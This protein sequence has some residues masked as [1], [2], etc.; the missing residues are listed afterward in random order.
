MKKSFEK[1]MRQPL[2]IIIVYFLVMIIAMLLGM[3]IFALIGSAIYDLSFSRLLNLVSTTPDIL[4]TLP[5]VEQDAY[6]FMNAYLNF[7][8]YVLIAL[9]FIIFGSFY[10]T[11]DFKKI[12]QNKKVFLVSL[13]LG[14]VVVGLLFGNS[15]LANYLVS[16]VDT[17][18]SSSVNQNLLVNM[19]LNGQ[20]PIV[21][22][23]V[24]IFAPIVEEMVFRK[25]IFNL[26][27]NIHPALRIILA[28]MIF[29]IP[30][31]LSAESS[32]L[33]WFIYFASYSISGILL[34]LV[35]HFSKENIYASIITHALN[36]LLSFVLLF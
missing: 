13:L 14:L 36:N 5:E 28:G 21:F 6:Y 11:E 3:V 30:H 35:Y 16:L 25:A 10:F 27:K 19:I 32:V 34:G 18:T 31:M 4:N 12:K 17:N 7:F 20:A 15:M 1:L 29:A 22:I 9:T 8:D 24:L 26:L 23:T 33:V 2:G